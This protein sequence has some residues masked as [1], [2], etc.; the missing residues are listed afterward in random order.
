MADKNR[1]MD[2][3]EPAIP[4]FN[5]YG[6]QLA[7][8]ADLPEGGQVHFTNGLAALGLVVP[9]LRLAPGTM[10]VCIPADASAQIRPMLRQLEKTK[11]E[12]LRRAGV[13]SH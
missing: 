8:L 9:G 6:L 2:P 5:F 4:M 7:V 11:P 1:I 13:I 10:V 12:A 3:M